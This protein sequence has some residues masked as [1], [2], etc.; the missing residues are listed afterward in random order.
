M[1]NGLKATQVG[2]LNI[3][4]FNLKQYYKSFL[5]TFLGISYCGIA[6]RYVGDDYQLFTF[7]LGCFPYNEINHSA[8][9]VRAFVDKKLEEYK[10]KL[11]AAKYVVT[12]NEPK[13]LSTFRDQ[14][15]HVGCAD[16]YLN[17]QLQHAF[18]SD[19]IHISGNSI[20]KVEC[21]VAQCIFLQVKRIVSSIRRSHQQQKLSK[22]LQTYSE[23]RFGGA[24]TMLTEHCSAFFVTYSSSYLKY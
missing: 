5:Y 19:E 17:K 7:I 16:H 10:L 1:I 20:E 14:C 8:Q 23:T 6:L 15:S 18:E 24:I 21:K 9:R 2:T 3:L 11:D 13:M 4:L 12:D 22:K